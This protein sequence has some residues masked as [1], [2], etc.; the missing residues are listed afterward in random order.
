MLQ[1]NGQK[2]WFGHYFK[3]PNIDLMLNAIFKVQVKKIDIIL[4]KYIRVI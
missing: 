1:W 4:H 3:V 2:V